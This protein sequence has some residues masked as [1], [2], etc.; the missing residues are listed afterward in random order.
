MDFVT[1]LPIS[2]SYKKD[3]YDS[4]FIIVDLLTK[5]VYY[6]TVKIIINAPGL[7]EVIINM[8]VWHHGLPDSNIINRGSF[9]TLKFWSLLCYF[10]RIKR[11]LFTAFHI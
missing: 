7:A 9:F 2:T 1:S 6:K 5:M 11:R 8:V 4:I 3:S 10:F